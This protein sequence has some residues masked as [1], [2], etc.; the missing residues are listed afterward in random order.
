MK[1]SNKLHSHLS[2]DSITVG[3]V[4]RANFTCFQLGFLTDIFVMALFL[5][6]GCC[7][8][9]NSDRFLSFFYSRFVWKAVACVFCFLKEAGCFSSKWQTSINHQ[10]T[11]QMLNCCYWVRSNMCLASTANQ[12]EHY[13]HLHTDVLKVNKPERKMQYLPW[14]CTVMH[15]KK[16]PMTPAW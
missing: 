9:L 5:Y 15:R 6:P 10:N 16:L 2:T 8:E 4:N 12:A 11:V 13:T 1:D 7:K 3:G 14:R